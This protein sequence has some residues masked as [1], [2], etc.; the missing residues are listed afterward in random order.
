MRNSIRTRLILVFIGL[1]IGP[2]L[3]VGVILGWQS[4]TSL[5][6]Q[7]LI[8]QQEAA[9]RV[10]SQVAAFFQELENELRF[11][12][13]TQHL[14]ELDQD[15]QRSVL[16]NLFAYEKAFDELHLLNAQGQEQVSVYR[17][18]LASTTTVD[19]SKADEFVIPKTTQQVYYGPV[20][21]DQVTNEPLMTISVPVINLRTGTLEGVLVSV[22]RIKKVW[23]LIAGIQVGEGQSVYIVDAGGKV[24]AHRNPSVVLRETS[25]SVPEEDGI[26]PGLSG[27]RVVLAF[28][29][30][31]LGQ[32]SLSIVAEQT[33]TEALASAI[34]IVYVT[35]ILMVVVVGLAGALGLWSVR[36]IVQ[37]IQALAKAAER[38]GAGDLT[39]QAQVT[40]H[41]E[42]GTLATI[43]NS[44]TSRLRDLIS[45]L[46]QRVAER[47]K[48][49]A[50]SADVS[51][52]LSTILDQHQLVSEVV[53][54]IKSAF[55][56]YHAHIYLVDE[57]TGDLIMAGGTGEAGQALLA[58]G[59]KIP[60]GKGLTGRAA[61]TNSPVLVPD[62]S[63]DPDWL[64]NPLLPETKSEAAVPIAIGGQVLGVLDVQQNVTGGLKQEDVDL[65]Q[66][67]ANQVAIA[68]RNARSYTEVQQRAEREA[69]IASIG[70]KIQDA[71]SV[72]GALQVAVRELGRALGRPAS[73]QLMQSDQ[74]PEN[75]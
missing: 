12:V 1:A 58:S 68:L 30:M 51:R 38:I 41:D 34:Y 25:F 27:A 5:Q 57:K 39:A 16:S 36:Q 69:L 74:R 48:A 3:L 43:F 54:E 47:T 46:E 75:R 59:H 31:S 26:Y 10:T 11:T 55:N 2:L 24:V 63:Q 71:D 61:E 13:Q 49:L 17:I 42:I 70:Q 21:Y 19:R 44:M 29:K 65:L 23:D 8:L 22:A 14:E 20:R 33:L 6:Q 37:P 40:S 67:I 56:Y 64:P 35:L 45:T 15:Q 7:A 50:T 62:T 72:K 32:Q 53:E 28:N 60:K 52:R 18:G 73:V 4:F 66:V 9:K